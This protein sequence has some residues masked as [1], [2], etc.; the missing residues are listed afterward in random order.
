MNDREI[1]S[2]IRAWE[3]RAGESFVDYWGSNLNTPN[4]MFWCVGKGI[5]TQAQFNVWERDY[6]SEGIYAGLTA[7]DPNYFI[8][9]DTTEGLPYAIGDM[10]NEQFYGL[11]VLSQF[12]ADSMIYQKRLI[13]FLND[14]EDDE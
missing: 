4:F 14:E 6:T 10:D 7:N 13:D 1:F 8:D 5:L 9:G 2:K 11:I 12:I 3:L